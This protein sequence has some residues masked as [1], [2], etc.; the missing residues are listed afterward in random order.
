MVSSA[1][2]HGE[3]VTTKVTV[4]TS[5][6]TVSKESTIAPPRLAGVNLNVAEKEGSYTFTITANVDMNDGAAVTEGMILNANLTPYMDINNSLN[7]PV[8]SLP[9]KQVSG[10]LSRYTATYTTTVPPGWTKIASVSV[11]GYWDVIEEHVFIQTS[12]AVEIN[13]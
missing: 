9:M 10:D 4:H 11:S 1:L 2:I 7:N 13:Y 12:T 8:V 5:A 3:T 6:G